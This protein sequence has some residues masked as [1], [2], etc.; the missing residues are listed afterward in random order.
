[1]RTGVQIPKRRGLSYNNE[2]IAFRILQKKN[3][4]VIIACDDAEYFADYFDLGADYRA[5]A[6]RLSAFPELVEPIRFGTGLRILRQDPFETVISFI[7][8]ANN[9]IP[10]I[11]GILDR[12]CRSLGDEIA[13]GLYS[14]PT[15]ERICEAG[16]SALRSFG[17]GYRSECVLDASRKLCDFD[18]SRIREADSETGRAILKSVKGIGDKIAS[19]VLLFAFRK[20]DVFPMDVWTKRAFESIMPGSGLSAREAEKALAERYGADAGYAQQYLYYYFRANK[21]KHAGR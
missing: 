3:S 7:V 14:F 18:Y 16:E 12:M 20:T 8:S 13:E 11:R 6:D 1:M 4:R 21:I 5:I 19:C 10:R 9:N 15:A 17:A 2:R